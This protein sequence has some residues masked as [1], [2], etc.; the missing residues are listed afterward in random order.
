MK[1]LFG[2]VGVFGVGL[3]GGSVALGI[4]ERFL[5]EEVHAYDQDPMA[6]EKALFLGVADRVHTEVGPWVGELDLGILAAPVGALAELGKALAPW[7][8]P[9]S[10]WTD[11]GSVKAKVVAAGKSVAAIT[12]TQH[13]QPPVAQPAINLVVAP[14]SSV[15]ATSNPT[16]LRAKA[17]RANVAAPAC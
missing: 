3:L 16:R 14:S 9:D 7:A 6:L 17:L 1:P 10:L 11:V 13:A 12:A 5:A 2:K 15:P 4:K 8:H